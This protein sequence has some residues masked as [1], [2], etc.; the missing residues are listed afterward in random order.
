LGIRGLSLYLIKC[1]FFTICYGFYFDFW[2]VN[3][4]FFPLLG[5]IGPFL[6]PD[7]GRKLGDDNQLQVYIK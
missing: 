3:R 5:D 4:G 6:R 2:P 7:F 1:G